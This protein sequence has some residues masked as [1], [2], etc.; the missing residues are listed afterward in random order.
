[1][2][3][4]VKVGTSSITDDDGS[5][6]RAAIAKVCAELVEARRAGHQVILVSSG[7]IAAGLPALGL[8]A[9]NR[10][11]DPRTLQAVS[12]V[13]QTRLMATYNACLAELGEVVA[14]QVLLTADDFHRRSTYNQARETLSRLLELGAIPI[15]NEN[16]TLADDEIR[17]GDND[18]IA[19]LVAQ[20]IS[21][22]L[23]V[24]L[25][26][27]PGLLTADPRVDAGASL[28]HDVMEVDQE[29]EALAGGSGTNRGSGGMATKLGAAKI[30][31]W[32]GVRTVIARAAR[33][34]VV[35]DA[36]DAVD[37]VGTIV[38][39]ATRRLSA[40]KVWIAFAV[41]ISGRLHVD[42]GAAAA[43]RDDRSLLVPGIC[44][45]E[46]TFSRKDAVEVLGPDG[47]VVAKGTVR[48]GSARLRDGSAAGV[49]IHKDD[50]VVL[51]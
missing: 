36:I 1:M 18:R 38:W 21:A 32:S 26:D 37:G 4:V 10:P 50:L 48:V 44:S 49:V 35:R 46:G 20:A 9:R 14:G 40:R 30:A 31:A 3:V 43:L 6:D 19:A 22:D 41:G 2:I 27:A 24:L 11:R 47:E 17:Y 28:I 13:G 39:P 25:T 5:I 15:I 34:D 42:A 33:A 45:V 7:A 8:S 51:D 16:D 29:L 23:L 12:A